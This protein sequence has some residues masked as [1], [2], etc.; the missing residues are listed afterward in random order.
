MEKQRIAID[1]RLIRAL[2]ARPRPIFVHGYKLV[3]RHLIVSVKHFHARHV[4]KFSKPITNNIFYIVRSELLWFEKRILS[5]SEA[6]WLSRVLTSQNEDE[7]RSQAWSC[8]E[9]APGGLGPCI[10][11][12]S[13]LCGGLRLRTNWSQTKHYPARRKHSRR[14]ADTPGFLINKILIKK[15]RGWI[16]VKKLNFLT[17]G[18]AGKAHLKK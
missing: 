1:R 4:W 15:L 12:R 8:S 16:P 3:Y 6:R 10:A 14:R 2:F 5:S 7:A 11:G 13:H 18:G 9:E 17:H